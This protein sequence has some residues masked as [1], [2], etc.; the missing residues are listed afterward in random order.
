MKEKPN[1]GFIKELTRGQAKPEHGSKSFAYNKPVSKIDKVQNMAV[2]SR[3]R[4]FKSVAQDKT[5]NF[6]S[7][8][9]SAKQSH[10]GN[11]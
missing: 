11:K 3:S 2:N 1:K 7:E 4:E 9:S 8:Q 10:K 5:T 6:T